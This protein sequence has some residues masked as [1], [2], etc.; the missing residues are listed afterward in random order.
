MAS[1]AG[2]LISSISRRVRDANNTAHTSAFVRDI[3]DRAQVTINARQE[4]VLTDTVLT[5]TPGKVLYNVEND[6][7]SSI[8]VTEVSI[9]GRDLDEITWAN[10]HRISPTYLTDKSG[11]PEAWAR[12]GR[13]LVAIYPAPNVPIEIT[14]TASKITT[15]LNDDNIPLELRAEDEDVVRELTTAI[16]LIRQRDTDVV[17][18]IIRRVGDKMKLQ[19]PELMMR[20]NVD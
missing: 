3:L 20:A 8:K 11:T 10:L 6:L 18:E 12:I 7:G 19:E 5:A 9:D 13:S 14:F 1:T 4:Y 2:T 15:E 17:T 16:L